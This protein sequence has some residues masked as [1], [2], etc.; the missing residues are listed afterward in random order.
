LFG[1]SHDLSHLKLT[2][3]FLKN[4]AEREDQAIDALAVQ[5]ET[6]PEDLNRQKRLKVLLNTTMIKR[7]I[8]A[9][10]AVALGQFLSLEKKDNQAFL[11]IYVSLGNFFHTYIAA[12]V[13]PHASSGQLSSLRTELCELTSSLELTPPHL[14]DMGLFLEVLEK[15]ESGSEKNI[16]KVSVVLLS[17]SSLSYD[18]VSQDLKEAAQVLGSQAISYNSIKQAQRASLVEQTNLI[19]KAA[20]EASDKGDL[21]LV[22]KLIEDLVRIKK[23]LAEL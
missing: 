18:K 23:D 20:K 14:L 10:A 3:Y 21:T 7:E 12:T 8:V 9:S 16:D 17:S 11:D 1:F 4:V 22:K 6:A 15:E 5:L 13:D 19:A 2:L